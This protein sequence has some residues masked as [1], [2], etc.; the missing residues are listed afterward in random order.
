MLQTGLRP[1]LPKP[2]AAA[3]AKRADKAPATRAAAGP[4]RDPHALTRG[5]HAAAGTVRIDKGALPGPAHLH[6][7]IG[8]ERVDAASKEHAPSNGEPIRHV[9]A[10]NRP[11][12]GARTRPAANA[13]PADIQPLGGPAEKVKL[14]RSRQRAQS[15]SRK[16]PK[17]GAAAGKRTRVS[18]RERRERKTST[19][20]I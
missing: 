14:A 20:A 19:D 15:R 4:V 2:P 10:G 6:S 18:L 11:H 8:P 7:A 16:H 13:A 1:T 5:Q 12:S 9:S 17:I 3:R